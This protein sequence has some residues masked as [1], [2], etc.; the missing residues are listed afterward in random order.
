MLADTSRLT[1]ELG[2][3]VPES[4]KVSPGEPDMIC[5]SCAKAADGSVAI[6]SAQTAR[7]VN[8]GLRMLVFTFNASISSIVRTV[9][10]KNK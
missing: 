1:C 10:I 3:P 8:A 2:A 6:I 9:L 7:I 4:D 5:T